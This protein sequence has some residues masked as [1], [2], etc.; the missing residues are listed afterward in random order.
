MLTLM[1]LNDLEPQ[2]WGILVN[3]LRLWSVT[4]I[5]RVNCVEMTNYSLNIA[6][7]AA[8]KGV[9]LKIVIKL[10]VLNYAWHFDSFGVPVRCLFMDTFLETHHYF[11]HLCKKRTLNALTITKTDDQQDDAKVT[12]FECVKKRVK[13]AIFGMG[14]FPNRI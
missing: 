4:H 11:E 14:I 13:G 10:S 1:A 3:S 12:L 6:Q 8:L 5:S 7:T 2:K 9:L